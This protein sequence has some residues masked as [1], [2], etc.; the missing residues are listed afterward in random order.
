MFFTTN[1]VNEL[2][3]ET[4]KSKMAL[5]QLQ[6]EHEDLE[7]ET[8]K[9]DNKINSNSGLLVIVISVKC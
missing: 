7:N 6:L 1:K 8:F 2:R 3:I 4:D 5:R 9:L